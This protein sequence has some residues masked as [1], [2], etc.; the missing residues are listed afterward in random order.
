[1]QILWSC[2]IQSR[3]PQ[4]G[5]D[6]EAGS[7]DGTCPPHP[8]KS[9]SFFSI[10]TE[11]LPGQE[12][13]HIPTYIYIGTY[14]F[15]IQDEKIPF[16][17]Q[18]AKTNCS[19]ILKLCPSNVNFNLW[20]WGMGVAWGFIGL[21]SLNTERGGV[22]N[23]SYNAKANKHTKPLFWCLSSRLVSMA[24]FPHIPATK[25]Q[26]PSQKHFSKSTFTVLCPTH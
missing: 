21:S 12:I 3:H 18:E 13:G 25:L 5:W 20:G 26:R 4:P 7:T 11:W 22:S 19:L 8:E 17:S 23:Y 15:H 14:I 2:P 10:S 1:M 24:T 16:C 6:H 9:G